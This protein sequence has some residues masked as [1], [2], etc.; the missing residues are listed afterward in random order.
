MSAME[1][2]IGHGAWRRNALRPVVQ[3]TVA[4]LLK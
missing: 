3:L 4:S 1:H 2:M